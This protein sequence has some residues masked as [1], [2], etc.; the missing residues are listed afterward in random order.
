VP[1][2]NHLAVPVDDLD[3]ATAFYADLFDAKVVPSPRFPLPVAWVALGRLQLHLVLRPGQA[4]EAY[5]FGIAIESR[6]Q[7]EGLYRRAA[8]DGLFEPRAFDHHLYEAPGGV[9]QLYLR[10]PSGNIVE[11]D[12]PDVA[13]LDDD[14]VAGIRRWADLNEQSAWNQRASVFR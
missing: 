12:Y 7:F 2:V 14:I 1:H 4:V 6:Q 8:R 13:D 11:C 10:D 5:H 9:V 3:R